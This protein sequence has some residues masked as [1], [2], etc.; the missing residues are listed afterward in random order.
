MDGIRVELDGIEDFFA[1][2]CLFRKLL[3]FTWSYLSF[4]QLLQTQKASQNFQ[5]A[6]V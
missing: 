3:G 2:A 4:L 6:A 1:F 5:F